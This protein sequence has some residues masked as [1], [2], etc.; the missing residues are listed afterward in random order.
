MLFRE[1]M[2]SMLTEQHFL[3]S[4]LLESGNLTLEER[5]LFA[6]RLQLSLR[7]AAEAAGPYG[8]MYG[9]YGASSS[10]AGALWGQWACLGP[11]ML[12]QQQLNPALLYPRLGQTRFAPYSLPPAPPHARSPRS[13]PDSVREELVSPAP[14]ASPFAPGPS[15]P[16][17]P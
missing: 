14:S 4:P 9:L 10:G 2:E 17:S 3:R 11:A 5:A 7:A 15:S 13:S 8:A 16:S 1:T 12:A 6:A